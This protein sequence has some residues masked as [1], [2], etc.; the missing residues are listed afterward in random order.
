MEGLLTMGQHYLVFEVHA[1]ANLR[2]LYFLLLPVGNHWL[3]TIAGQKC[4]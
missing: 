2:V 1:Y 4:E 3:V